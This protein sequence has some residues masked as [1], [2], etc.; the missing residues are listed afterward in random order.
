MRDITFSCPLALT[1]AVTLALTGYAC[2]QPYPGRAQTT[3]DAG[4]VTP[5]VGDPGQMY[6]AVRTTDGQ[7]DPVLPDG[8]VMTDAATSAAVIGVWA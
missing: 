5:A 4:N 7:A 1:D 2:L 6:F 3:D 8:C